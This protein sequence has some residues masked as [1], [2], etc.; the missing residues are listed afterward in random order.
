MEDPSEWCAP[1]VPVIKKNGKVRITVDYKHLNKAVKRQQHM[2]PNLEDLAPKLAGATMF[3]SL[4]AAG[5][6][7]QIPLDE[8]SSKITHIYDHM[9]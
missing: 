4:D 8:K 9:W 7:Y 2:L 1:M 5:G 3:S 6:Y